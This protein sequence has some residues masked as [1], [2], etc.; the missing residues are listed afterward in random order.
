M[1]FLFVLIGQKFAK[2]SDHQIALFLCR[3][4]HILKS[5]SNRL[6]V[7][8]LSMDSYDTAKYLSYIYFLKFNF[9]SISVAFHI[10]PLFSLTWPLQSFFLLSFSV[11]TYEFLHGQHRTN[12][13]T[14]PWDVHQ[15]ILKLSDWNQYLHCILKFCLV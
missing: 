1:L 12:L 15:I 5:S 10:I 3:A 6:T 14:C 2:N 4:N 13:F 11:T 9:I 8:S 7:P